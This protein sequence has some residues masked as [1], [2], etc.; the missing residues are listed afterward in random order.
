MKKALFAGSFNPITLG[1]LDLIKRSLQLCDKLYVG[2]A[3]NPRKA[4]HQ[5]FT[6][7]EKQQMLQQ[8]LGN[9][10][11][12]EVVIISGLVVDFAEK[13]GIHFLVRGLRMLSD[14]SY[15]FQMAMTNRQISKLDTT[16]LLGDPKYAHLSSSLIHE[17][18]TLGQR[19]NGFIPDEIEEEVFLRLMG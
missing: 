3:D 11:N 12:V 1:H 2:V 10:P 16:F 18:A 6:T 8:V 13:E 17:I 4:A 9:L 5:Y 7:L 15:E 14:M 19:L